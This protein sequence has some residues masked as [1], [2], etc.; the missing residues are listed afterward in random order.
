VANLHALWYHIS[1]ML[2]SRLVISLLLFLFGIYLM[3]DI[4]SFAPARHRQSRAHPRHVDDG[5]TRWPPV[6][7]IIPARNEEG[8]IRPLLESLRKQTAAPHEIIVVDERSCDGTARVAQSLGATTVEGQ[9][10]PE[11]WTGKTWGCWQGAQHATGTLLLFLDAD[12]W[13]EPDGIERIVRAYESQGGLL[14]VQPFHVTHR[15]YEELSAFFNVV[16]MAGLN[17]FTPHGDRIT[18]SGAF[19]ACAVC[20]REDYARVGGHQAVRGHVIESIPLARLF[21]SHGLPVRCF[22]GRGAVS[23]QMYPGGLG[24]LIE[25][26][27]KG[28]GSG[29]LAIRRSFL[30]MTAAWICGCFTA[31][32]G[33][34][35]SLYWP[36]T[37]DVWLRLLVYGLYA[38]Q[39]RWMLR[40]IGGFRWWTAILF[41]IPLFFFA[42]VM[43]RSFIA[44][45]ILGRVTWRGRRIET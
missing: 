2:N 35:R 30:L 3:W 34:L 43:L 44:I 1:L 13:L 26:W 41:P 38:L 25:G 12:T 42:L 32:F 27:S 24:E 23:F 11:G 22:G 28:F 4:P 21:L 16:L 33:L 39:V 6:S 31:V 29:A 14:T 45:H 20:S 5:E 9:P 19:G 18:P 37:P 15:P 8:R 17:A 7:I 36:P 40:R 10:L